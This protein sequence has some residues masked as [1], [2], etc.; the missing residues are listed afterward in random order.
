M[1]FLRGIKL[2]RQ[3]ELYNLI[4][5]YLGLD[6]Y[7]LGLRI[8]CRLSDYFQFC[9]QKMQGLTWR[10]HIQWTRQASHF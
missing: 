5:K 4:K 1:G 9:L 2:K 10:S 8:K 3:R 6:I 7:K